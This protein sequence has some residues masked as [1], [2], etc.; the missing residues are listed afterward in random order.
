[1]RKNGINK[2]LQEIEGGVCAP[3]GFRASGICIRDDFEGNK[4]LGLIFSDKR[5][6]SACVY[7]TS[8]EQGAPVTVS[9]KHLKNGLAQAIVFNSGNANVFQ[10]NGEKIA[11]N[12]CALLSK[13]AKIDAK[14]IVIASTGKIGE[15]LTIAPFEKGIKPLMEGLNEK[16]SSLCV[17]A[18]QSEGGQGKQLAFS[19]E[20]GAYEAKIG[21]VFKANKRVCPNMATFL[22]FLTTDVCISSEMLQKAL[23][24][25]VKESFN[26]LNIDG[27]SSPNDTVCIMANGRAGNYII[28][29]VDS[30]YKKFT[31]AL[32]EVCVRI[33]KEIQNG[34][35]CKGFSCMAKGVKSKQVSR[36]IAKT[37]VSEKNVKS[38]LL[39]GSLDFESL[40]Y[41]IVGAGV[42]IS[43]SKLQV[44]LRSSFGRL[45][46]WEDGAKQPLSTEN[47]KEVLEG[48]NVEILLSFN[49]GNYSSSAYGIF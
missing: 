32:H 15:A 10:E 27:V 41:A 19:F 6:P 36:I 25:E 22:C 23:A 11:E 13:Q 8:K 38:S 3:E 12:I 45:T 40:L 39:Q 4:G 34:F 18:L 49:E 47:V 35:E 9:K 44:V 16:D 17:Q 48:E 42:E 7:S 26:Q 28:D 14:D 21:V 31:F 37:I 20:L 33:C 30:E 5:C 46:V 2:Q 1:M 24:A 29:C 43:L